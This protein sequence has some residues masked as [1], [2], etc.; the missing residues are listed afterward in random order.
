MS[1]GAPE[2]VIPAGNLAALRDVRYFVVEDVRTARRY[3]RS[4]FP[5]FPIDDCHFEELSEHT[6][7][8]EVV[9]MLMP[10]IEGHDIGVMSEAGCP[11][12]AD[13]GSDLVAAA[14]RC[15]V[16]VVPFV[17]P[18]SIMMSLMG[19]GFNGQRFCFDGYLP[20]D[21]DNR[22]LRLR[23]LERKVR[24]EGVTTIFIETPYRN[25]K[26]MEDICKVLSANTM[27]CVAVDVTGPSQSIRTMSVQQWS[28]S[29]VQLEKVPTI[30]LIGR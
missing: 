16:E 17:G 10:A 13:P 2:S 9:A 24:S 14:Q 6:Q 28:E 5:D 19:S 22:R 25:A 15:R 12:V 3:L 8:S 27:V 23:Q 7:K 20:V 1:E 11:A 29:G 4:V 26:L 30:F 21:T 18:S